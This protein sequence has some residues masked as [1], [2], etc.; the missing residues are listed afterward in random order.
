MRGS[1]LWSFVWLIA[2]HGT[3]L[4]R[5]A[6]FLRIRIVGW[7][8]VYGRVCCEEQRA[9][10]FPALVQAMGEGAIEGAAADYTIDG[11]EPFS[12]E[13]K[14]SRF[15]A[16]HASPRNVSALTGLR[17]HIKGSGGSEGAAMQGDD[18]LVAGR[19][20]GGVTTD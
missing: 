2:T 20:T 8:S 17:R 19:A 6:L 15:H 13:F 14:Y 1:E 18:T 9:E 7:G 16:T 3:A 10:A 5:V 12:T 4:Q 11:A